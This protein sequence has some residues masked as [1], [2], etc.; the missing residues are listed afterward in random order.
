[1]LL[2]QLTGLSG[3]GKTTIANE[4]KNNLAKKGIPAEVLDGDEYRK[5]LFKDLGFTRS[6]RI[7]N[8]RRLGFIAKILIQ[9]KVIVLL[10]AINPY[11]ESRKELENS[12]PHVKT[13]FIDCDLVILE[14]RDTKDLYKKARLSQ[15]HPDKIHNLSGVN[16][17]YERPSLPHLV[18]HTDQ[19]TA[20][21]SAAKL[22]RFVINELEMKKEPANYSK[23]FY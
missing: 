10:A 3:S 9:H 13:V 5:A 12:G 8:I 15:N 21:E 14:Q 7:E 19:E 6:D 4:V 18:I 20:K 17:P 2:I 1:M 11:E 22:L 16:D 23:Q